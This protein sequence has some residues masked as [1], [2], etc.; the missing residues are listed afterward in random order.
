VRAEYG[1]AGTPG[2]RVDYDPFGQPEA[3]A[4][5]GTPTDYG[6]TGEPRDATTGLV[7]LRARWYQP[8][9][10]QF[11]SRDPFAGIAETPQSFHPYAYAHN[12]PV[13]GTDPTGQ[14]RW[15]GTKSV[16][17]RLIEDEYLRMMR[18]FPEFAHAEYDDLPN[19]D[20]TIPQGTS[21]DLLNSFS[22]DVWEIEPW[23]KRHEARPQA[24]RYVDLLRNVG[25]GARQPHLKGYFRGQLGYNLPHYGEMPYDWNRV[26][27]VLGSPWHFPTMRITS[28]LNPQRGQTAPWLAVV[29]L[30]AYAP[31]PGEVVFWLEPKR[32]RSVRE[33]KG[34]VPN[35]D[36]VKERGWDPAV[37]QRPRT[38]RGVPNQPSPPAPTPTPG[39]QPNPGPYQ[40]PLF[41]WPPKL[42]RALPNTGGGWD[43]ECGGSSDR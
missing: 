20:R 22:G 40:P 12:D 24:Q 37:P 33:A 36:L 8:G 31:A 14:W 42:P 4:G 43:G 28:E 25:I 2:L 19:L 21:I 3:G 27:W 15:K 35:G 13:N 17:H 34:L 10:G 23:T 41:P 1:A 16:Y 9:S 5:L 32:G 26:D 7:Q 18:L 39:T 29:D 11:V 6:F 38:P 30:V